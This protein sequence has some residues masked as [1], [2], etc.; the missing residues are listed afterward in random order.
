VS[1]L[2]KQFSRLKDQGRTA[3]IPFITAGDPDPDPD[4]TVS[5]MHAM[6]AA[7][8]DIIELGVPFSD[9]MAEGPVIQRA[10]ERA[11]ARG[12]SLRDCLDMVQE[13]RH[14]NEDTPVVLMGY[15]NPIEAMGYKAFAKAAAQAGVDGILTVDMPPEE[16]E[17]LTMALKKHA[18]DPIFLLAPTST[19]ERII[20][21]N[22]QASGFIY[23]V[24]LRGVTGA[25]HMD[26]SE[27]TDRIGEIRKISQ[28][29]LAVGFGINNPETAARVSLLA[30]AVVVGS[31]LVQRIEDV[32]NQHNK[33]E[34]NEAI[35]KSVTEFVSSLRKGMDKAG[36]AA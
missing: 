17:D 20:S 23:Y 5:I 22:A 8:A 27:V 4:V 25:K 10:S 9:P 24:S 6:V 35:M 28:L 14:L 1:R 19:E 16:A 29:P 3:L 26:M 21:V 33:D 18:L 13:F 31:A 15:L 7:G 36:V 32:F 2:K 34:R 12:V 30:D 11:V